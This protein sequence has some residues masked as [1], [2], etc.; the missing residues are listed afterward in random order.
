MPYLIG[1][2]GGTGPAGPAGPTGPAPGGTGFVRVTSGVLED[3]ATI[4]LDTD[5]T[6]NADSDT[7]VASQAALVQFVSAVA[8]GLTPKLPVRLASAAALPTGSYSNGTAGVGATFTVTATGTLTVDGVLTALNNRILVKDQSDA[9]QNGVYKVTTAGAVG[10]QAVLTRDTDSDT[11]SALLAALYSVTAGSANTGTF[12]NVV[13]PAA[14]VIGTDL[15]TFAQFTPVTPGGNGKPNNGNAYD[16]AFFVAGKPTASQVVLEFIAVRSVKLPKS[17][18]GSLAK[19]GTASGASA[20][21]DIQVNGSSKGT[22]TFA[23]S[24]TGTFSFTAAVTLAAG[25]VLTVIAPGSQD[26][27]LADV[28]VTFAGSY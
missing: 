13:N 25:D 2:A 15:I 20:A 28:R 10:V 8:A 14:P 3:P 6:M 5:G 1:G 22:L 9:T 16:I 19:A 26:T 27:T 12:W 7:R 17:L 24:A 11:G 23:T 21:F 4:T 18:N